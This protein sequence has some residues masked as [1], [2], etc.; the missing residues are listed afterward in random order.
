MSA[1]Y[2][3]VFFDLDGTLVDTLGILR[4]VYYEFLLS[5]GIQ[6]SEDEFQSF[7]GPS[8]KEVVT[9]INDKYCLNQSPEILLEKYLQ[10]LEKKYLLDF[11]FSYRNIACLKQLRFKGLTI[12]LVTSSPKYLIEPLFKEKNLTNLF[13]GFVF[14]DEVAK[15]KPDPEIYLKA[16]DKSGLEANQILVVEDSL[17]GIISGKA[18]NLFVCVISDSLDNEFIE[19]YNIDYSIRHI[20]EIIG[21]IYE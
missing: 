17:N 3:G 19:K 15:S 10:T 8:L 5:F 11:E 12:F 13:D 14:G 18:A 20:D 4:S 21:I 6:G 7:N 2:L 16:I 1:K 9:I